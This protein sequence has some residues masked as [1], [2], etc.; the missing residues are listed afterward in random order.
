MA[1]GFLAQDARMPHCMTADKSDSFVDAWS[2]LFS[3]FSDQHV[4][5]QTPDQTQSPSPH[6]DHKLSITSTAA[7]HQSAVFAAL[8]EEM[9]TSQSCDALVHVQQPHAASNHSSAVSLCD[10]AASFSFKTARQTHTAGD[11]APSFHTVQ[12]CP[13]P[14]VQRHVLARSHDV[15]KADLSVTLEDWQMD[16]DL[17]AESAPKDRNCAHPSVEGLHC[18]TSWTQRSSQHSYSKWQA[19]KSKQSTQHADVTAVAVANAA[20]A[21]VP[22]SGRVQSPPVTHA[23]KSSPASK[24]VRGKSEAAQRKG[25]AV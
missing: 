8:F 2:S 1:A 20:A 25:T 21:M 16:T 5:L 9:V 12:P 23:R 15:S 13:H 22:D 14:A 6:T 10:S 3:S 17:Q 7:V 18:P 4:P 24:R 19:A 11:P